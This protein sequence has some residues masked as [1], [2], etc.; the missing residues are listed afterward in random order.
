MKEQVFF[1][2]CHTGRET[3][4]QKMINIFVSVRECEGDQDSRCCSIFPKRYTTSL[5]LIIVI[6][7]F[8]INQ[9]TEGGKWTKKLYTSH[10]NIKVN[11]EYNSITSK[12]STTNHYW[13]LSIYSCTIGT[14]IIKR[15]YNLQWEKVQGPVWTFKLST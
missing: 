9:R 6:F 2:T 13:F 7:H 14:W 3:T 15:G 4:D 8:T 1:V 12:S 5:P 11:T 10:T